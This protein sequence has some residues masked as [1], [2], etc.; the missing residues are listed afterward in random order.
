MPTR[1]EREILEDL[2]IVD[3]GDEV[4][5]APQEQAAPP[6]IDDENPTTVYPRWRGSRVEVLSRKRYSRDEAEQEFRRRVEARGWKVLEPLFWTAR[7][8]CL[9]VAN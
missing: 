5:R 9:R 8:W 6:T 2:G 1:E 4:C 7:Y 3:T